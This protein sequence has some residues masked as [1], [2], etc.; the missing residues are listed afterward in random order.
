[1]RAKVN[2]KLRKCTQICRRRPTFPPYGCRM[3][4]TTVMFRSQLYSNLSIAYALNFY[5]CLT[6]VAF[7]EVDEDVNKEDVHLEFTFGDDHFPNK[8]EMEIDLEGLTQIGYMDLSRPDAP[9][10]ILISDKLDD[11]KGVSPDLKGRY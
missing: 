1:M 8:D 7:E 2:K 10:R 3:H 11:P 6:N 4:K 9:N 5:K